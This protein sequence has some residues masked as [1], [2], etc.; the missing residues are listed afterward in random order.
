MGRQA[1]QVVEVAR[2]CARAR[3]P[4][5]APEGSIVFMTFSAK[6]AVNSNRS[7]TASIRC[8]SIGKTAADL[9]LEQVGRAGAPLGIQVYRDAE[10]SDAYLTRSDND[11]LAE[12]GVPAHTVRVGQAFDFPDYHGVGDEWQK[13]NYENMAKVDRM[14]LLGLVDLANSEKAPEWN[15]QNPK[16]EHFRAARAG[17]I[18]VR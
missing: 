17:N 16:T 8:V 7:T 10:A 4:S 2:P 18:T 12:Q 14:V 1:S 6:S 9:N 11:A 3:R 13:I 5:A 15:A